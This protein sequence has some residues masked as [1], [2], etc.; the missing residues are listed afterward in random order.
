[1]TSAAPNAVKASRSS[2]IT[3]VEELRDL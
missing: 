1:M 3:R 2:G